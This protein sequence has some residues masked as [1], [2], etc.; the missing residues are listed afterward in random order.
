[1]TNK[2]HQYFLKLILFSNSKMLSVIFNHK[3]IDE[4]FMIAY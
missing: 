3:K 1:M 4:K 2:L